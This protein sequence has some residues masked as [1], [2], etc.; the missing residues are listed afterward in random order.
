MCQDGIVP[1][2]LS[3]RV[4]GAL[5]AELNEAMKDESSAIRRVSSWPVT[6]TFV[7]I[8]VSDFSI[9]PQ[10]QQALIL[11]SLSKLDN[12]V[13]TRRR[14]DYHEGF[15]ANLVDRLSIGDGYIYVFRHS[16]MAIVFAALLAKALLKSVAHR[17]LPIDIHFRMGLHTGPVCH[18]WDEGRKT[19]WN[20]V[21]DGINGGKRVLDTIGKDLDD[22]IYLSAECLNAC[23]RESRSIE[24]A[25][26]KSLPAHCTN[27]GRISDKHGTKWRVYQLNFVAA[28]A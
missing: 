1:D 13:L 6:R 8:D 12:A 7:Y 28:I 19:E 2:Q 24:I 14:A 25:P 22:V 18:F 17:S 21:G 5:Y 9:Y 27:K 10:A 11:A 15:E 26:P 16:Y 20:F 4:P 3:I 23:I